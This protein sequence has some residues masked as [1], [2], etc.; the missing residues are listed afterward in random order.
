MVV[1][2]IACDSDDAACQSLTDRILFRL[3]AHTEIDKLRIW[4]K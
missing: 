3:I 1:L 4:V 2:D